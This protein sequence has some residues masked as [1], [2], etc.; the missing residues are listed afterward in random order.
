MGRG[1]LLVIA[2]IFIILLI[3]FT[4]PFII[5]FIGRNVASIS[6]TDGSGLLIV[7]RHL[8]NAT[9]WIHRNIIIIIIFLFFFI[10]LLAFLFLAL[11]FAGG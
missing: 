11:R 10:T 6:A 2:I 4:I 9:V 8:N 3:I 5:F 1:S 7:T